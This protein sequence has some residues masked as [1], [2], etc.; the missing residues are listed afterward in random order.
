[1]MMAMVSVVSCA[2]EIA[3][4]QQPAGPSLQEEAVTVHAVMDEGMTKVT[5]GDDSGETTEVYWDADDKI[6]ITI[7]FGCLSAVISQ[8]DLGHPFIH[9]SMYGHSFFLK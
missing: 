9:H 8:R 3:S 7:N 2:E 4:P 6:G 1:M 5:L